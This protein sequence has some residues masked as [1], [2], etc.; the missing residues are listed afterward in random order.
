M[1][2]LARTA[3]CWL[4]VVVSATGTASSVQLAAEP[5][6]IRSERECKLYPSLRKDAAH[7]L[8]IALQWLQ[9]QQAD[10]GHWSNAQFPA[11]TALVVW[12]H[13]RS[14]DAIGEGEG[15]RQHVDVLPHVR[16]GLDY[17]LR[18][19]REDGGIYVPIEGRKGGGLKNYNTAICMA[20]L[21]ATAD[22]RYDDIVDSA[23][24]CL[25]DL[26]YLGGGV[27]D[28]GMGYDEGTNR[29][30]ADMSNTYTAIEAISFVD[31]VRR[32]HRVQCYRPGDLELMK[33]LRKLREEASGT[34]GS[35]EALK[36]DR[37]LKFVGRCQNL[38]ETND[39]S[40]VSPHPDDR[41]GFIYHPERAMAGERVMPDGGR[42]PRSYASIS[43]AGLLSLIYADVERDDPRV[44]GAYDWIRRHYTVKENPGMGQQSLFFGYHT[45]AKALTAYGEGLLNLPDG[46][47]VDWRT[48]LVGKLVS[49]QRI[50]PKTGL[51]Y[52]TNDN[53]R[54]WENDP[55]LATVYA[56]LALE[57]CLEGTAPLQH[58]SPLPAGVPDPT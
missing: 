16:K 28:G 50:D 19:V 1:G 35:K 56:V 24:Q 52:W 8:R 27:F 33:R 41:G 44:S 6:D 25:I 47:A 14:P 38:P 7:A 42:Y 18:C 5:E 9:R 4:W 30:Y 31:F 3:W 26:Q 54:F 20:A 36:W 10:D 40:W 48:D 49:L 15:G 53:G 32:T 51:G 23:R 22:A 21:A 57:I 29:A 39:G 2:P 13:L 45:M 58:D 43:Y 11:V 37:A 55:V 34:A 46:R 12:A 17:I